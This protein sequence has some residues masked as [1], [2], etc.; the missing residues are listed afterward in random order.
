MRTI[1]A[2]LCVS[3]IS[4]RKCLMCRLNLVEKL[5][6][7]VFAT[8]RIY[9]S[10][11]TVSQGSSSGLSL[12]FNRTYRQRRRLFVSASSCLSSEA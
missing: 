2:M 12:I 3:D 9:I 11:Q 4:Y 10:G 8:F 6:S 7:S 5:F 1:H